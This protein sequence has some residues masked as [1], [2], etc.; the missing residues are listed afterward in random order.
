ML[1]ELRSLLLKLRSDAAN[2]NDRANTELSIAIKLQKLIQSQQAEQMKAIT[3]M[4]RETEAFTDTLNARL[5]FYR[6]LQ[7]VSDMVAGREEANR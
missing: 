4:E 6:Q 7:A 1:S 5:E 2:G 3:S